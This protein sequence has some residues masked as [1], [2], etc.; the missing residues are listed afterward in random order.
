MINTKVEL[1]ILTFVND[2]LQDFGILAL[3]GLRIKVG[4][5]IEEVFVIDH[6]SEGFDPFLGFG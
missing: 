3:G 2:C 1:W 4:Q 6:P 5:R